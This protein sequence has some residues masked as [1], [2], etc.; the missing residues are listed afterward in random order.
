MKINQIFMKK[1][2]SDQPGQ[3]LLILLIVVTI[4]ALIYFGQS[5]LFAS[6]MG[7]KKDPGA[8]RVQVED[9]QNKVDNYNQ[10]F[11]NDLNN[12]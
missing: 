11:G 5:G 12:N 2:K 1:I 7:T 6:M 3:T 4:M 8:V 9:M 10:Q